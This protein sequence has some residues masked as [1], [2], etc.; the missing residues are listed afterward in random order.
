[1]QEFEAIQENVLEEVPGES[2]DVVVCLTRILN[3]NEENAGQSP[4]RQIDILKL[5]EN[6]GE[7]WINYE[8][9]RKVTA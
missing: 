2:E 5:L 6:N 3:A 9:R 7:T 4:Q 1:M 8:Y